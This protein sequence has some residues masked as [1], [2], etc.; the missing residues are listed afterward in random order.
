MRRLSRKLGEPRRLGMEGDR[1]PDCE[2][3]E[4]LPEEELPELLCDEQLEREEW[5]PERDLELRDPLRLLDE[6]YLLER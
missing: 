2:D 6:L 5:D 3:P 4:P 1:D